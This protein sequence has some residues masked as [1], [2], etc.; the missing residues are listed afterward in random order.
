MA[1]K[2]TTAKKRARPKAAPTIIIGSDHAGYEDKQAIVHHLAARGFTI[3][4]V[5]GFDPA[6]HDD[7]PDYAAE[8]AKIVAEDRDCVGILI[9][10]TGTGMCIA[11]NKVKGARA[12]VIYDEYSAVMAREHN[13]ANIACLR[14]R[15]VSARRDKAL[16]DTFL[17]TPFSGGARH[18]RRLAKVKALEARSK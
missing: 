11:A 1:S 16:V 5:G 4:D 9:C 2:Q 3:V 10:G 15:G 18:V 13:N 12:A 6:A 7:Y 8:A 14:A 17:A